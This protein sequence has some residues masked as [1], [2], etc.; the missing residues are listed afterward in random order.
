MNKK[1]KV[2]V[3]GA[4][5]DVGQGILKSLLDSKLNLELYAS[6]IS[7]SSSW[8][9]KVDNSFIF[10]LVSDAD[11]IEFLINF[12]NK[13][14]IDIYFPTVDSTLLKISENKE[15]IEER[16]NTK[17]FIDSY[18]KIAICDDKYLT[19]KFL[20]EHNFDAPLTISMDSKD[21]DS[22]LENNKYPFILKTK[23]GNGAKNVIKINEFRELK[24]FLG[25]D[26]WMLQEY[27]NI[28]SEITSG[29][30]IGND[31]ETKGVYILKRTLKCGSTYQAERII[32]TVLEV[33]II[34]IAKVMKMKYLNIQA[35][36]ENG[37]LLPF[38]FNGRLSGTTGAIRQL[39]NAPEFYIREVILNE[40]IT[41]P[42]NNEKIF[43]TRYNEEVIY[44]ENDMAELFRRSEVI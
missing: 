39:F 36:Y 44:T 25:N 22:F 11:F 37:R 41:P 18:E 43:F 26:S 15:L 4:G 7:T 10:P 23:S 9:Y 40:H 24:P 38:E 27:L 28:E 30:Y 35:V 2:L 8:L 21:L 34:E 20:V 1:I 12:L 13:K 16:T 42:I 17:I 5:G 6:C 29:I 33:K 14:N 32:D 19:N 3:D 31:V